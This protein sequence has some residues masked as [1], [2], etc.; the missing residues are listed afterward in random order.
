MVVTSISSYRWCRDGILLLIAK[1]PTWAVL[2]GGL[3]VI[4]FAKPVVALGNLVIGVIVTAIVLSEDH[5]CRDG[6]PGRCSAL[7]QAPRLH[8]APTRAG[9]AC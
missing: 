8:P 6:S 5:I 3:Y 2:A 9:P 1:R 7:H 4:F